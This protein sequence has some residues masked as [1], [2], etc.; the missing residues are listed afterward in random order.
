MKEFVGRARRMIRNILRRDAPEFA[1]A[2]SLVACV[3]LAIGSLV[4]GALEH[5]L[6][7][8]TNGFITLI[9]IGNSLLFLAAVQRSSR[10]PDLTFNYGYGKYESL[11]I[12]ASATLLTILT[13]YTLIE[14]VNVFR[15]PP[16]AHNLWLLLSWSVLS[17]IVMRITANSL[18]RYANRFHMPMFR[19][20]AELWRVDSWL[21]LGVMGGLVVGGLLFMAE[22]T[23]AAVIVDGVSAI[24]LL[25]VTLKV[26]FTHGRE[27]FRQLLDR[28]L[29][30][31]MQYEIIAIIA[32]NYRHMCEFKSV[33]TR[34][35]GKDI[36]IE[37]DLVMPFDY[38]LEQLYA[39]E[40][41]ILSE[42]RERFPT[43]IPRVYVMPCDRSCMSALG[44]TCPVK[45]D[46]QL[47]H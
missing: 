6:I 29:P 39:L 27:A 44:S 18:D 8:Q 32:Q 31:E 23:E 12:L 28:T 19:Y 41:N 1:S 26:P 37:I 5:S 33:H 2:L 36:F 11:A 40:A 16:V 34:Q 14:A 35:S 20:D 30:D 17:L 4:L 46:A 45:R 42:L 13:F 21:E 7:I 25:L 43:A 47:Q 15:Q 38:T 22:M 10:N 3:I 9:D 24:V